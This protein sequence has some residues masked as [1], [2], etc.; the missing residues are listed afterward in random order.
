MGKLVN[1]GR[2]RRIAL[3]Y[4]ILDKAERGGNIEITDLTSAVSELLNKYHNQQADPDSVWIKTEE[5]EALHKLLPLLS[6]G[7]GQLEKIDS[8]E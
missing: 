2:Q 4:E 5:I 3:A 7:I 8:E 1:V 6:Q